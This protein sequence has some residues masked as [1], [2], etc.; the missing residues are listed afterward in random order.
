MVSERSSLLSG[1]GKVNKKHGYARSLV[2]GNA[3]IRLAAL[4]VGI[5]LNIDCMVCLFSNLFDGFHIVYALIDFYAFCFGATAVLMEVKREAVPAFASKF[6]DIVGKNIE[7]VRTV[8]GRGLF[9]IVAGSLE[10]AQVRVG[11][12]YR[13]A[14]LVGLF[15]IR[16]CVLN[17]FG[18]YAPFS[19][20]IGH[21]YYGTN[22][23]ANP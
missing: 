6:H 2:N 20:P 16:R 15:F 23:K 1:S 3:T 12:I 8:A 14:R 21:I 10:I 19:Q 4:V 13:P 11:V 9:Y 18:K 7:I 17:S 22:C 5:V